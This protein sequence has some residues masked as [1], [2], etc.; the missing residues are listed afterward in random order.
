MLDLP[1]QNM[2]I[3]S[4][5]TEIVAKTGIRENHSLAF[6]IDPHVLIRSDNVVRSYA[7][8]VCAQFA[9]GF[10]WTDIP[11]IVKYSIEAVG[12]VLDVSSK[13]DLVIKVIH[14]V[15]DFTD[16]PF[17]PDKFTDPIFKAI[18]VSLVHLTFNLFEGKVS[19]EA[20]TLW[21]PGLSAS[22]P[23]REDLKRVAYQVIEVF[24]DGFQWSDITQIIEISTDFIKEYTGLN[25][26]QKKD[27]LIQILNDVIDITD[28]P[29]LP[30]SIFDPLFKQVV[31]SIIDY[32]MELKHA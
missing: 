9:D 31:P 20:P 29:Y 3:A 24:K 16:T 6:P 1:A 13:R 18:A 21:E 5:Q 10:Q 4:I 7:E 12:D 23:S 8:K 28:T 22:S 17:V 32:V 14:A 15:I 27:C 19:L 11:A 25:K 2:D 26:Q 30:D